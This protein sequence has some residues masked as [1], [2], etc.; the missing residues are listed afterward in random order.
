MRIGHA[1]PSWILH[2][3]E[4]ETR[5]CRGIMVQVSL[6]TIAPCP[7]VCPS[8]GGG[9][10]LLLV[11]SDK[12]GSIIWTLLILT[13]ILARNLA[14]QIKIWTGAGIFF[15]PLGTGRA[16]VAKA[17]K[18]CIVPEFSLGFAQHLNQPF[19]KVH[20]KYKKGLLVIR[21]L[22]NCQKIEW[23]FFVLSLIICELGSS[24][25]SE[26]NCWQLGNFLFLP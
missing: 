12:P 10:V 20:T 7:W 17:R 14:K 21:S 2:P 25:M 19:P 22:F 3:V 9:R 11:D 26:H 4:L 6:G 16:C 5:G 15:L 24:I 8:S 1:V 13:L 18:H 23:I